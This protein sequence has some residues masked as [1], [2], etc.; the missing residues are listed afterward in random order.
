MNFIKTINAE[1]VLQINPLVKDYWS[2]KLNDWKAPEKLDDFI[3]LARAKKNHYLN[4][5]VLVEAFQHTYDLAGIPAPEVLMELQG[6]NTFTITT[7]HQLNLFTGPAFFVI[8]IAQTIQ[9]ARAL[10]AYQNEF[11]FIP[12]YWMASEDHDL[13]EIQKVHWFDGTCHWDKEDEDKLVGRY[14][15]DDFEAQLNAPNHMLSRQLLKDLSFFYKQSKTLSEAHIKL[16]NHL[17]ADTKELLILEPD[18]QRLKTLFMPVMEKELKDKVLEKQIQKTIKT[19]KKE[20]K[21]QVN[22]RSCHLF[23][24]DEQ[25]VRYRIDH[26][27]DL[28]INGK[29]Y[30]LN[31]VLNDLKQNP[32]NYSPNALMRPLYQECILPNVGYIGGWAEVA[33]WLELEQVFEPL[34]IDRPILVPRKTFLFLSEEQH[35]KWSQLNS[36]HALF[37]SELENSNEE[38]AALIETNE[39]LF[40]Q[41]KLDLEKAATPMNA[42]YLNIQENYI[43]NWEGIKVKFYKKIRQNLKNIEKLERRKLEGKRLKEQMLKSEIF[44]KG[45]LNERVFNWFE[46][47]LKAGDGNHLEDLLREIKP[48]NYKE[49]DIIT[50]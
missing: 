2:Q 9:L 11:K 21:I 40:E 43:R 10:N 33:Y 15:L 50:Y 38:I 22:P 42:P 13:E 30:A 25:N 31:E 46:L 27:K 7:G 29:T 37:Q 45:K 14:N 6:E 44:P 4:R 5:S 28:E 23:K 49:I 48:L 16:V 18:Q 41:F 1:D 19:F 47:S 26:E 3:Q 32:Q 34:N 36:I 39:H 12:V 17:F 8:K 20:Y 35:E 24:I